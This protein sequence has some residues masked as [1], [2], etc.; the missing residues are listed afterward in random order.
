ME[1]LPFLNLPGPE[2]LNVFGALAIIVLVAGWLLI[3]VADQTD[4]RPPPPVPQNPDPVEV[5]FLQGG[6]NQVI[7]MISYDLVQRG[8]AALAPDD[9][10]APTAK[11]PEP[12]ALDNMERRVLESIQAKPKAHELFANLTQRRELLAQLEPVR[13]KLAA[14]DLVKP[15]SVK[16]WRTRVQIVGAPLLV[17][18]AGAKIYVALNAGHKNVWYLVFLCIAAVAGLFALCYVA[19]RNHASRRGQAYLEAMKL[20][21][22]PRLDGALLEVG[23]PAPVKAFEGASLFLIGLYGFSVLKGTADAAFAAHFKRASGD[24]GG[25]GCGS[26]C[27]GSCGSGD[28]GG[29]CGGCGGG[30]D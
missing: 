15:E 22:K 4:K 12:G 20:A 27:G 3:R 14:E 7:R 16:T 1:N 28:G 25:G 6:V 11:R 13:A 23:A 26:S 10:I 18:F 17:G 29:G 8:Y 19:T 2:F 24:G 9:R 5:A 30:G 21:Y